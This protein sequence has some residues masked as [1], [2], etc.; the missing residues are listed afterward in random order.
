MRQ[1]QITVYLSGEL[2]GR[3]NRASAMR[4]LQPGAGNR[5]A[6]RSEV[7]RDALLAYL[8]PPAPP[9]LS[10]AVEEALP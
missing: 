7:V 9:V 1:E 3:L 5:I 8:Q 6:R 10:S 4:Q 2:L